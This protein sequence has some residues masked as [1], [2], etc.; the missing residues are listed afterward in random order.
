M[1]VIKASIDLETWSMPHT[2]DNC[3]SE[4]EIEAV[5]I[6]YDYQVDGKHWL[7][8]CCLCNSPFRLIDT[9]V[10]EIVKAN[11][12]KHRMIYKPPF[13]AK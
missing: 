2:C 1:K 5:D 3:K 12:M 7:V 10:P 13:D 8:K 6:S 11:V 9:E 4:V